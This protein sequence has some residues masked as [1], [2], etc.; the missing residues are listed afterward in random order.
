VG[1]PAPDFDVPGSGGHNYALRDYTDCGVILAFYPGDFTTVCTRQFCS[2]RDERERIE[3]LGIPM[4]GIS[5]QSVASHE[6]FIEEKG[7]NVPLLADQDKSMA[8]AYGVLG[9][10]GFVRR[11]IFIVDGELV[12]RHRDVKLLGATYET[13]ADIEHALAA[14]R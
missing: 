12:I 13:V 4:L 7:L 5:P 6:R 10:G 14:I 8:R 3:A 9:P 11:A 1:D 2:Y